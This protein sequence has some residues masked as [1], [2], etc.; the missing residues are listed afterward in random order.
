[1]ESKSIYSFVFLTLAINWVSSQ[2]ISCYDCDPNNFASD[3]GD[4]VGNTVRSTPCTPD[5]NVVNGTSLC[6][7]AYL[8]VT[9]GT[10][11]ASGIYRGCNTLRPDVSDFCDWFKEERQ[12]F[13]ATLISC[14]ACN[15]T[16]CNTIGFT[17]DGK[18]GAPS[19]FA[20]SVFV[21]LC[22]ALLILLL[23]ERN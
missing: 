11:N 1:M 22:N 21:L 19:I 16:R 20:S 6:V 8:Y 14:V 2:S 9:G 17:E 5:A 12:G 23:K 7:S 15:T 13:N 3:C 10:T 4:P 18:A